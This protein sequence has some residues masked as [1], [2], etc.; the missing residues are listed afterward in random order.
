VAA[1]RDTP[2][3]RANHDGWQAPYAWNKSYSRRPFT[4]NCAWLLVQHLPAAIFTGTVPRVG[5]RQWLLHATRLPT[6]P[7]M[8]AGRR[9]LAPAD[10][11]AGSG[12]AAAAGSSHHKADGCSGGQRS[13]RRRSQDVALARAE[14]G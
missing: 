3:H 13:R 8:M 11:L 6:V 10:G 12:E 2:A 4:V 9:H 1:A 14:A 5:R 7:I